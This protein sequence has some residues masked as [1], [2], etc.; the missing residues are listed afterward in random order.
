[1]ISTPLVWPN[2]GWP[3]V[4]EPHVRSAF[5]SSSSSRT[6]PDTAARTGSATNAARQDEPVATDPVRCP[7]G[8]GAARAGTAGTP[9]GRGSSPYRGD[10]CRPSPPHP[11]PAHGRCPPRADRSHPNAVPTPGRLSRGVRPDV[12]GPRPCPGGEGG[13]GAGR[14]CGFSIAKRHAI[15]LWEPLCDRV[16]RR[17]LAPSMSYR[18]AGVTFC[19]PRADRRL[20]GAGRPGRAGDRCHRL[21]AVLQAAI[22]GAM[23]ITTTAGAG[24]PLR[25]PRD[26]RQATSAAP[27]AH[28]S[29]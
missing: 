17:P 14:A 16:L 15:R 23:D 7:P 19:S 21:R 26:P 10:R 25:A 8:H 1:M 13:I 12:A 2:S 27:S 24:P 18:V 29:R 5:R 4:S 20:C 11:Q 6:R 3:G 28:T 9:P 22:A